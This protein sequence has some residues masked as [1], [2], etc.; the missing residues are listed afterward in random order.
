MT[1][2]DN[3]I[4]DK[5]LHAYVDGQ[6]SD[7]R[8]LQVE[9]HLA[10]NPEARN[11]VQRYQE[12]NRALRARFD[13]VAEEPIPARLLQSTPAKR[14]FMPRS[15]A[16]A[17][18]W[19]LIGGVIGAALQYGLTSNGV[20][21]IEAD[22]MRPAAFAHVVYSPEVR[23]PVEI[24]ADQEAHL[25]NWLSKRLHTDIRAP[26]LSALGYH[27]VGGRLLPSTNRMA[28][29]FMYEDGTAS[30]ITLYVR[31]GSWES[32][33]PAFRYAYQDG[34]GVFYW[35]VGT[36]GYAI[37]GSVDK[38]ELL[39]IAIAAYRELGLPDE[40]VPQTTDMGYRQ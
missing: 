38:Q 7:A 2:I 40:G 21:A 37:S 18:A 4:Q 8:R 32:H 30:R 39:R 1:H 19:L 20:P 14:W 27:L 33:E 28:A 35:V 10:Q 34:V 29:Q 22:L 26:N 15:V 36:T 17:A 5:D 31:N 24:T 13:P 6:L 23:H 9:A 12:L 16:A 25:V 3:P 11:R